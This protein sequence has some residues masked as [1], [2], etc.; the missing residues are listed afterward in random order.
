MNNFTNLSETEESIEAILGYLNFSSGSHDPQFFKHLNQLYQYCGEQ[1]GHT[2]I[3]DDALVPLWQS[4]IQLLEERLKR[5][6]EKNSTFTNNDQASLI[7]GN[8]RENILPQYLRFHSDLLFHQSENVLY[9]P[10]FVGRVFEC[11]LAELNRSSK[12][13]ET[14]Q[15]EIIDKL[16]DYVC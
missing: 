11:L 3:E 1:V 16:N 12:W 2:Q 9:G 10:F 7:L 8:I 5:L 14:R 15:H 4:V 6:H 13:S